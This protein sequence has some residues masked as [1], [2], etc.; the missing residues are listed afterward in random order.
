MQLVR[1][2]SFTPGHHCLVTDVNVCKEIPVVFEYLRAEDV[3]TRVRRVSS[4][5]REQLAIIET[6]TLGGDGLST[7]WD[8]FWPDYQRQV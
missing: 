3:A 4:M 5:I 1:V 7:H 6:N 8:K 2:V